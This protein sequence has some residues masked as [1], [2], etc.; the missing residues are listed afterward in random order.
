MFKGGPSI[1]EGNLLTEIGKLEDCPLQGGLPPFHGNDQHV[2]A[3]D[4]DQNGNQDVDEDHDDDDNDDD[5]DEDQDDGDD[6]DN[7]DDD[8]DVNN[9]QD[10]LDGGNVNNHNVLL[11]PNGVSKNASSN[12]DVAPAP[13]LARQKI[14]S[15]QKRYS[16]TGTTAIS[17]SLF[18]KDPKNRNKDKSKKETLSDDPGRPGKRPC[19]CGFNKKACLI[20]W[21]VL[22]A[23]IAVIAVIV[24]ESIVLATA[25]NKD[26]DQSPSASR[27]DAPLTLSTEGPKTAEEE[28]LAKEQL[29]PGKLG[30]PVEETI[31]THYALVGDREDDDCSVGLHQSPI[32]IWSKK[33]SHGLNN[34]NTTL[35]L[36]EVLKS[37][38]IF[39]DG[40]KL[41]SETDR[42]LIAGFRHHNISIKI[43]NFH[44]PSSS[45]IDSPLTRF[46]FDEQFYTFRN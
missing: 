8:D 43:R 36:I 15:V 32:H 42:L 12:H 4:D 14:V 19:C 30:H 3:G 44:L 38:A 2:D 27:T 20:F 9:V 5:D 31:R 40:L 26:K 6:D 22:I 34:Q 28:A 13:S 18:K 33:I 21:I 29:D 39:L 1:D 11:L 46:G 35:D 17:G 7:D 45:I 41:V 37:H 10:L 25:G 24:A 16:I 23:V